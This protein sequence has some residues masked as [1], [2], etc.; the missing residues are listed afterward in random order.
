MIATK[1]LSGHRCKGGLYKDLMGSMQ[2][3]AM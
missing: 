3:A 2:N 1:V